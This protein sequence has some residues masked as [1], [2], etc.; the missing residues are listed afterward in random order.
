MGKQNGW[1]PFGLRLQIPV[2]PN[3]D[4]D[5]HVIII[6]HS[7]KNTPCDSD[8]SAYAHVFIIAHSDAKCV[9]LPPRLNIPR[10]EGPSGGTGRARHSSKILVPPIKVPLDNETYPS[11][12]LRGTLGTNLRLGVLHDVQSTG[13]NTPRKTARSGASV[14]NSGE[15]TP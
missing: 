14:C 8:D 4:Y 15:N 13:E 5:A 1:C 10:Y 2:S 9:A 11:G 7:G 12:T 6:A 3:G